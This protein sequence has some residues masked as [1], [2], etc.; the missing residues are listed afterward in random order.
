MIG[1]R[2]GFHDFIHFILSV[3]GL[4]G[5]P[6]LCLADLLQNTGRQHGLSGHIEELVFDGGAARVDYEDLHVLLFFGIRFQVSGVQGSIG[7]SVQVSGVRVAAGLKS[8]PALEGGQ[9]NFK[10]NFVLG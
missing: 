8:L 6:A 1:H 9:F 10:R 3:A 2:I 5:K 7:F 4:M